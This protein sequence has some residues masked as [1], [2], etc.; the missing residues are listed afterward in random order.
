VNGMAKVKV[1]VG[2]YMPDVKLEAYP[3]KNQV[4]LSSYRG[5]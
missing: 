2:D 1:K 3:D 5:K 4:R